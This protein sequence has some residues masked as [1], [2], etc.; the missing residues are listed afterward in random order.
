MKDSS[1]SY[2]V[3]IALIIL[4]FASLAFTTLKPSNNSR[5]LKNKK[6]I[7]EAIRDNKGYNN[8]NNQNTNNNKQN[9][10]QQ[11]NTQTNNNN[12]QSNT[13]TNNNN[14]Q[15][16]TQTN[17]NN[18][19]SNN[20]TNNNTQN[21]NVPETKTV[22]ER[23]LSA[24]AIALSKG[25]GSINLNNFKAQLK[26]EFG[27]EGTGYKL[28]ENGSSWMIELIKEKTIEIINKNGKIESYI[29]PENDCGAKGNGTTDD[30]MAIKRCLESNEKNIVLQGTY[31]ITSNIE[32]SREKNLYKGKFLMQ[33]KNANRGLVFRGKVR[34]NGT[35]FTSS[36]KTT[37]KSPHGETFKSTSNTDFVE[38]WGSEA[39]FINC[40]FE[41][42]LRAIR[43]RISTG[44]TTVPESLYVNNSEFVECKAPI[45]GY[46]ANATVENTTFKNNGDLYSGDHAIYLESF[47][48]KVL[49]VNNS[50]VEAY[51]SESGAAFQIYGKKNGQNTTPKMNIKNC[52]VKAN[53]IASSDLANLTITNTNFTS[54]HT[55]RSVITIENGSVLID[56][57]KITHDYFLAKYPNVPVIAKNSEFKLNTGSGRVYFPQESTNCKFINWGGTVLYP[58][59]KVT[60]SIFTRDSDHV[61]GKYY[62]GI[63]DGYR[64]DVTSSSF[65]AGDNISYN[66]PGTIYLKNCTFTNNIGIN[67]PNV[68]Q[69]G[70]INQDIVK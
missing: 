32:T 16:N 57:S 44:A 70:T 49:N 22:R 3:S 46:F 14:Q 13:Q 38:V 45:Q 39:R 58:N 34:M 36:I 24:Y 43:G 54:Q 29:T 20:Q 65:K 4:I 52:T 11:S 28:M 7:E 12:Q 15:S 21:N 1:N 42:A 37:G 51:N 26:A 50:K 19:Q 62:I 30:T 68:I 55:K 56:G 2:I 60:N 63:G 27:N 23:V 31:L 17:N 66:S 40:K 9:N 25:N 6:E 33:I 8:S 69:E 41:N 61:V 5:G 67:V 64:I 35:S 18:Q 10:N 59:T 47:G 48:S 53:G